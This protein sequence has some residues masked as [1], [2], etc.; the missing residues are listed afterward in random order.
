MVEQVAEI[1][2]KLDKLLN[3]VCEF[4]SMKTRLTELEEEN[5]K[6]KEASENTDIEISNL[7]T[8]TVYI[9][10]NM[11]ATT[12]ELNGLREEVENL[13]RRNIK[14]EACTRRENIKIFGIKESAGETNEKTEELVRIM[15]KEKMKIPSD[16][17][18]DIRFEHV[19]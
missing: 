19:H 16:L 1:N 9:C 14:L 18:D 4:D 13:K 17:V 8:T 7:K 5:R 15:L 2:S 11:D 10:A 3:V 6:L 12:R